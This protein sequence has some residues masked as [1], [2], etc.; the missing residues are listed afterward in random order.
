MTQE[1]GWLNKNGVPWVQ[2]G[3]GRAFTVLTES[4]TLSAPTGGG[5]SVESRFQRSA[6]G[7]AG[8]F[9]YVAGVYTSNPERI[10]FNL[11]E[12]LNVCNFLR[13]VK[14]PVNFLVVQGCGNRL[15]LLDYTFGYYFIDDFPTSFDFTENIVEGTSETGADVM[16]QIAYS[17]GF[18]LPLK[19]VQHQDISGTA[20]D[21]A[22]NKVRSV[23]YDKC[24]DNC[25]AE[26]DG[27]QDFWFVTDKDNT[28]GYLS[29]STAKFLWTTNG[30]TTINSDYINAFLN[31]DA[32]DVVK[33]GG[34]IIA[35]S[36]Q[37]GIAYANY[38]NVAAGNI[39]TWR[40][41]TGAPTS[42]NYPRALGVVGNTIYAAGG[43]GYIWTST[44]G[45]SFSVLN[46][47]TI[48]TTQINS[49]ATPG[50]DLIWFGGNTGALAKYENGVLT[51]VTV[52]DS[53]GAVVTANI[54]VVATPP[55][56]GNR[57]NEVYVGTSTGRIFKSLDKGATWSEVAIDNAGT[58]SVN[59]I[60]FSFPFGVIMYVV[61]TNTNS[62]SRVLRD[63]TGGNGGLTQIEIL[64]SFTNPTNSGINSIAVANLNVAITAGEIDAT[65]AYIGKVS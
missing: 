28:P 51:A 33:Y 18:Q 61:Q 14:C 39:G 27:A 11:M 60:Q 30:G 63:L 64:G 52:R 35:A 55:A 1:L 2:Q 58:G 34:Y 16:R 25:S 24:L 5:Q 32:T 53:T 65:Y 13:R 15:T 3:G 50:C 47:G 23:G 9:E 6:E 29:Q 49:I 17:A 40:N 7:S 8:A 31:G 48:L 21:F 36:P 42:G 4:A 22:I 59:D 62:Q 57:G 12:R 37:N 20:S 45:V 46:A 44:D 41:A 43:G 19:K 56:Q 38:A 10:T 54:N 26:S